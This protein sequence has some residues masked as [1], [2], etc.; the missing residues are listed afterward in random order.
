MNRQ[1]GSLAQGRPHGK[2]T[3]DIPTCHRAKEGSKLAPTHSLWLTSSNRW[4]E[5][6]VGQTGVAHD[7]APSAEEAGRHFT[8]RQ[9]Q[10]TH[11]SSFQHGDEEGTGRQPGCFHGSIHKAH[12]GRTF[13]SPTPITTDTANFR[14]E[15]GEEARMH[16]LLH[17]TWSPVPWPLFSLCGYIFSNQTTQLHRPGRLATLS[18]KRIVYV[19]GE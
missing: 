3:V 1:H 13:Q 11:P 18:T 4:Q 12:R 5:R 2:S 15:K 14:N 19:F 9:L 10:P 7:R 6:G 16:P 17:Q 8:P